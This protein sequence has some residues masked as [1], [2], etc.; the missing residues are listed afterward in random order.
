MNRRCCCLGVFLLGVFTG[1]S[2][3]PALTPVSGTV[4]DADGKPFDGALVRFIPQ[5]ETE[6]HGGWGRTDA[7]GKYEITAQRLNRKGLRPGNYKVILTRL[8]A[9]DGKPLPPDA[10]P[11]ETGG[12]ESVPGPYSKMQFTPL[13]VNVGSEPVVF[14]IPLKVG[15]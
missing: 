10:R 6:G 11:I 9:P 8:L 13:T 2:S 7:D 3:G 14:N 5:G 15:E 4:T 12:K 1:C